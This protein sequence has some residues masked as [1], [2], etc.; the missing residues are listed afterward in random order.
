MTDEDALLAAIT[1]APDDD[2]PRLAYADWL[3]EHGHADRAEFIR[4]Q[5]RIAR[6]A[7]W[8]QHQELLRRETALLGRY[9]KEWLGPLRKLLP[10]STGTFSRGFVEHVETEAAHYLRAA[11][12]LYRLFPLRDVAVRNVTDWSA[13]SFLARPWHTRLRAITFNGRG[14]NPRIELELL[15]LA[16]P[17]CERLLMTGQWLVLAWA[18]WSGPDRGT[19]LRLASRLMFRHCPTGVAVRPFDDHKEFVP[20]CGNLETLASPVWLRFSD[21]QL[22]W[23]HTGLNPPDEFRSL[24]EL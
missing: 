22:I 7:E 18:I 20:W 23:Q 24:W 15:R 1:A 6:G 14:G 16:P 13:L 5:C 21:G 12:E 17:R 4:V 11:P 2:A 3:D 9:R 10:S 8:G 19:L